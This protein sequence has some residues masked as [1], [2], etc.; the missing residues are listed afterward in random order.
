M[1]S[2]A[3]V[4]AALVATE[5]VAAFHQSAV[6]LTPHT[7]LH[8]IERYAPVAS[9]SRGCGVRVGRLSTSATTAATNGAKRRRSRIGPILQAESSPSRYGRGS[10][11]WPPTNEEPVRLGDSF[12]NGMIPPFASALLSQSGVD[13]SNTLA[14]DQTSSPQA[15]QSVQPAPSSSSSDPSS[16]VVSFGFDTNPS[17][18]RRTEAQAGPRSRPARPPQSRHLRAAH[19]V[20]RY[21]GAGRSR[22]LLGCTRRSSPCRPCRRIGSVWSG[23]SDGCYGRG[24]TNCVPDRS[25]TDLQLAQGWFGRRQG[26]DAAVVAASGPCPNSGIQSVGS[27]A[28]EFG[29]VS[30]LVENRRRN[31]FGIASGCCRLVRSRT[32]QGFGR[33]RCGCSTGFLDLLSGRE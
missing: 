15:L 24:W 3:V 25:G 9:L 12:P 16:S 23:P 19:G 28:D 7:N 1:R 27:D 10:E 30:Q 18:P 13:D 4:S 21:V 5:T 31:G 6:H 20:R 22:C 26:D 11:I 14:Q 29:N 17:Q 33:C 2:I 32:A 8:V